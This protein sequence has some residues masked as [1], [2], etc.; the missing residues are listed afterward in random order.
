[1][2]LMKTA[3][4]LILQNV[5]SS[6]PYVYLHTSLVMKQFPYNVPAIIKTRS[7]LPL[8]ESWSLQS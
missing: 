2:Y 6:G 8:Q 5:L 3:K 1:M 7:V 4:I